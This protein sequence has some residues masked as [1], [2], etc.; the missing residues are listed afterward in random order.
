MTDDVD[1][2]SFPAAADVACSGLNAGVA[3]VAGVAGG[4]LGAEGS[5]TST[6][7]VGWLDSG[8]ASTPLVSS[9][10][11]V[12]AGRDVTGSDSGPLVWAPPLLLTVTPVATSVLEDVVPEVCELL[13]A[14]IPLSVAVDP[15]PVDVIEDGPASLVD[16]ADDSEGDASDDVESPELVED[17][18]EDDPV[19]SALATPGT[20]AMIAPIPSAAARAPTR[21]M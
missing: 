9:R 5:S 18:S 13:L 20:A 16:A 19:V 8:S 15:A 6:G 3:G 14:V 12:S 1:F 10:G 2:E 7:T 17:D 4:A 11:S 21:P